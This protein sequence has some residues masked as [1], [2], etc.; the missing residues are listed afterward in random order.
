ML[1]TE[2]GSYKLPKTARDMIVLEDLL[3]KEQP[4]LLNTLSTSARDRILLQL[5]Y[6]GLDA[7]QIRTAFASVRPDPKKK[8]KEAQRL[9]D[10]MRAV[11]KFIE[12]YN[13]KFVRA[14]VDVGIA[15]AVVQF[16]I[17]QIDQNIK[18]L[19]TMRDELDEATVEEAE[20]EFIAE[21]NFEGQEPITTTS[22]EELSPPPQK[23][24]LPSTKN[25]KAKPEKRTEKKA[26]Q[27]RSSVKKETIK[28]APQRKAIDQKIKELKQRKKKLEK[29]EKVELTQHEETLRSEPLPKQEKVEQ[30]EENV[31]EV[32]NEDPVTAPVY[33]EA[34]KEK[35]KLVEFLKKAAKNTAKTGFG[36]AADAAYFMVKSAFSHATKMISS[37]FSFNRSK[38]TSR[39][40]VPD[41]YESYSSWYDDDDDYRPRRDVA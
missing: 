14:S 25:K 13:D 11:L 37:S 35:S 5:E 33:E 7:G 2:T 27:T 31:Q 41:P 34:Q 28:K 30:I 15:K 26:K 24:S 19:E 29:F 20:N 4:H 17:Q 3:S 39:F 23:P 18:A 16:A 40:R 8:E 38:G 22:E 32:M 9:R 12:E 21:D 6:M 36:L 10:A 1:Q